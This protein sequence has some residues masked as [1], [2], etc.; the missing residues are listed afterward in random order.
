[1]PG[2]A[3]HE[4]RLQ[5]GGIGF[6]HALRPGEGGG[7]GAEH[8]DVQMLLRQWRA[9]VWGSGTPVPACACAARQSAGSSAHAGPASTKSASRTVSRILMVP[10]AK[11]G[12]HR[13]RPRSPLHRL[14][15]CQQLRR[16][17]H[18]AGCRRALTMTC[19]SSRLD[20]SVNTKWPAKAR[21][22]PRQK[23]ASE[24]CPHTI[25]GSEQRRFQRRPVARHEVDRDDRQREEMQNAQHVEIGLVDRI[26]H[27]RRCFGTKTPSRG[28]YQV[29]VMKKANSR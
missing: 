17:N 20:T 13:R 8:Q 7:T 27:R 22:T 1:M 4:R 26:E 23:I 9:A 19:S 15:P 16:C 18:D 11:P 10:P 14:I 28:K 5:P 29:I 3:G 24:C 6:A 25:A 12:L 2:K 21:N